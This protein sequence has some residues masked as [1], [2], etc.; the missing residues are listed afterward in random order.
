MINSKQ[1]N[2]KRQRKGQVDE[3]ATLSFREEQ[4]ST[5][6]TE[7]DEDEEKSFRSDHRRCRLEIETQIS[8]IAE[9]PKSRNINSS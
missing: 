9:Q 3:Q 1:S 7:E 6:Q 4:Q 8:P 5:L 2:S